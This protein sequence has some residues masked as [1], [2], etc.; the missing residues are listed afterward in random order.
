MSAVMLDNVV[1]ST[2]KLLIGDILH[3]NEKTSH[4]P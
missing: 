4:I 1:K 3:C 2:D